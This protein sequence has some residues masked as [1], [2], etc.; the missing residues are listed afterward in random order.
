M[1]NNLK[2]MVENGRFHIYPLIDLDLRGGV[3]LIPV[4]LVKVANFET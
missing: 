3:T 1:T 4:C 2:F